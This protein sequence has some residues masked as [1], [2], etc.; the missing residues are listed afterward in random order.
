M[1]SGGLTEPRAAG[2]AH[3]PQLGER[4]ADGVEEL[5]HLDR[6]RRRADVDRRDLVEAEHRAQPG[7]QLRVG[8]RDGRGELV[9]HRLAGLLEADLLERRRP[10]PP[11]A[12]SRCSAGWPAIIASSPAF[13]F[14]QIRGTAKNQCGRTSGRN[15]TIS[16]GLG[17]QVTWK[18]KTI[19][20]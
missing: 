2:L 10:A 6:R 1:R 12:F 15:A 13:S 11:A 4:Q 7:E 17:Q 14:S 20:R 16:R 9:G 8:L 5:Q 3:P 18:P 19:G